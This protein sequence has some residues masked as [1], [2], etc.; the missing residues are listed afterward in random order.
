MAIWLF[1]SLLLGPSTAMAED[2]ANAALRA[3][4][5][6]DSANRKVWEL[7]FGNTYNGINWADSVLVHRKQQR[8]FC[9]PDNVVLTGPQ[10][11]EMLREQL[12]A[13]AKAR[14]RPVFDRAGSE[15]R[16]TVPL[17]IKPSLGHYISVRGSNAVVADSSRN[18]LSTRSVWQPRLMVRGSP[19]ATGYRPTRQKRGLY[20][21]GST[22]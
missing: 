14:S 17:N 21:G 6:A 5:S 13:T 4:D 9:A 12:N 16:C 3:Y 19:A 1:G 11:I 2:N 10:V 8:L 22:S 20:K 15:K 7:I 18:R